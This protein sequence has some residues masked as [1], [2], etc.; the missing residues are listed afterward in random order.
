[1]LL[2]SVGVKLTLM[3]ERRLRVSEN[4]LLRRFGP[5]SV[6]VNEE[7]RRLHNKELYA[8]SS[9][10]NGIRLIKSRKLKSVGYAA[11]MGIGARF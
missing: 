2:F 6:E 1:M 3:E 11:R 8:P 4:K 5:T 9:L 7:W 10:L